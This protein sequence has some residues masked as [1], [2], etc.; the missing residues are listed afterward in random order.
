VGRSDERKSLE[1]LYLREI[2]RYPLLTREEE[3]ELARRVRRGDEDAKRR[4]ILS[5]LRLVVSI[6]KKYHTTGLSFLDLIEEGNLGLMRGVTRFNPERGV[7]FST[8]VSW[9]IK[10]A[11]N[12]AIANQA[13]TISIPIHIF[14]LVNRYLRALDG[15]PPEL[16]DKE[17]DRLLRKRLEITQEKLSRLRTL[18]DGIRSLDPV[19]SHEAFEHLAE[20]L[21]R[22]GRYSPEKIVDLQLEYE[23]LSRL[24]ERLTS[25]EQTVIR[26]R[27]GLRDGV[28]HTLAETGRRIGVSRERIRQIEKR[29]LMRLKQLLE[30]SE[31][32]GD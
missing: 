13:R 18:L 30:A 6:A 11:L 23:H 24:L 19:T 22:T 1:Y 16:D 2:S 17:T 31:E 26:I 32:E 3:V 27:Y 28:P 14:Q 15:V 7:R 20:D 10:Q 5:N 25:R 29:A 4:M 9:W 21:D 8:Y 12:R